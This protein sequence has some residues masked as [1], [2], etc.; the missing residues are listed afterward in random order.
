MKEMEIPEIQHLKEKVMIIRDASTG[1]RRK[2]LFLL[3][4]TDY[5]SG[6]DKPCDTPS[7]TLLYYLS[8]AL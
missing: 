5:I 8:D 6:S 7:Y 1:V 2:A 3:D 4:Y